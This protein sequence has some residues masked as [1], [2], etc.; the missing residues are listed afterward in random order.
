MRTL[1]RQI[2]VTS[3]LLTLDAGIKT[4]Q[5]MYKNVIYHCSY[6]YLQTPDGVALQRMNYFDGVSRHQ[7]SSHNSPKRDYQKFR[8]A[9]WKKFV[10]LSQ[11]MLFW[12]SKKSLKLHILRFFWATKIFILSYHAFYLIRIQNAAKKRV[13][14]NFVI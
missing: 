10:R 9:V 3:L 8:H 13:L 11:K 12:Q 14:L 7:R 6:R 2:F 4:R 5:L 1:W